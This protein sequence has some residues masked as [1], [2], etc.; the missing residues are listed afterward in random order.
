MR[1]T[2][3]LGVNGVRTIRYS[4]AICIDQE[5]DIGKRADGAASEK[6]RRVRWGFGF[7]AA[8]FLSGLLLSRTPIHHQNRN[9]RADYNEDHKTQYL[10]DHDRASPCNSRAPY[11]TFLTVQDQTDRSS[12]LRDRAARLRQRARFLQRSWV[13]YQKMVVDCHLNVVVSTHSNDRLCRYD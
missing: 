1:P 9:G 13:H 7:S 11:R 2:R 5:A 10:F 4:G 8:L 12:F 6:P 3:Y